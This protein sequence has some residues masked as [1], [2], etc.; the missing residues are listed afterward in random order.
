MRYVIASAFGLGLL[1]ASAGIPFAVEETRDLN[2]W[3]REGRVEAH[4]ACWAKDRPAFITLPLTPEAKRA[5]ERL[6]DSRKPINAF[7]F[8]DGYLSVR[9]WNWYFQFALMMDA[10]ND[11]LRLPWVRGMENP[12]LPRHGASCD[13]FLQEAILGHPPAGGWHDAYQHFPPNWKIALWAWATG[14]E[15]ENLPSR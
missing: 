10:S 2:K 12:G 3:M 9:P 14:F 13:A 5:Y 4:P 8:G 6:L 1:I 7:L 15:I 11:L